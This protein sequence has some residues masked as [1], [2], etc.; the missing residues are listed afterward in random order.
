M[1]GQSLQKQN[2]LTELA[3]SYFSVKE[4]VFPFT[5]FPGVDP[6]MGPEMKSTGE[7]MGIDE[8]FPKAF[9]KAQLAA[10]VRLPVKGTVFLSVKDSDK[11]HLPLLAQALLNAGFQLVATQGTA[12]FLNEQKIRTLPIKKVKEGRPHIVDSIKNGEIAMVIN[13]THGGQS[14]YDSYS[15][16][17]EALMHGITYYTT[18]PEARAALEGILALQHENLGVKSLQEFLASTS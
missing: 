12:A 9:A 10:G 6:L 15:I 14:I 8:S 1:A 7:V 11:R 2:V 5:K 3:P 18:I 16:R 4:A 17:R 13:T